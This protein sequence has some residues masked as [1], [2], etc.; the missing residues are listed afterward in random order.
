L[1]RAAVIV[2]AGGPS[3]ARFYDA[4]FYARFYAVA[5]RLAWVFLTEKP[6]GAALQPPPAAEKPP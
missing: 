3:A 6:C 5:D 1:R 2:F 4:R